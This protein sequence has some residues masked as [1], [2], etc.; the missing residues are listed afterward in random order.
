M[1]RKAEE[2]DSSGGERAPESQMLSYKFDRRIS[3]PEMCPLRYRERACL[4]IA[5]ADGRIHFLH[6]SLYSVGS[7]GTNRI[8]NAV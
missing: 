5:L 8:E 2:S 1:R 3:T 4:S 7:P 6:S